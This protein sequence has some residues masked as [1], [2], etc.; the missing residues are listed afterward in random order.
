MLIYLGP[1]FLIQKFSWFIELQIHYSQTTR[2]HDRPEFPGSKSE[3]VSKLEFLDPDNIEGIPVYRVLNKE[4]HFIDS[5]EDPEV[6]ILE[7]SFS[8]I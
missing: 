4:G 2:E 8:R 7:I 1:L 6:G 3:F 5:K